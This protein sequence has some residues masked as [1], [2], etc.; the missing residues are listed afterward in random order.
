MISDGY[1]VQMLPDRQGL[2]S[3]RGVLAGLVCTS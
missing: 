2:P 1:D 3:V